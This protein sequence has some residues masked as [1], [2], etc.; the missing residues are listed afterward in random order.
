M[1]RPVPALSADLY[2]LTMAAAYWMNGIHA[3]ASFELFVR[4]IGENRN[5]LIAAGIERALRY[6]EEF[7]FEP[8]EIEFLRQHPA[9]RQVD[10]GF[11]DYLAALRFTG[12]VRAM[13]EGTPFF[14]DEPILRVTAPVIQAQLFETALLSMVGF[15]TAVASK[16]ARVVEA[17]QGHPVSE[18]G[19]RHA[20]GTEAA[21]YAARAA[22][23]AGC[24]GT[25]NS[26][27]GLAFGIPVTGT[28]AHSYIMTY[29][30]ELESFIDFSRVIGERTTLLLDTYDT[31]RALESI[32]VAGLH[33]SAVRLDSGDRLTL[34][35]QVR[36]R[37]DQAGLHDVK[38]VVT[39]ELNEWRVD[40]LL[41]AGAP[42]D[43]F[44]VGTEIA[45]AKDD[46]AL[47]CVY[48]LVH[49]DLGA[50]PRFR[51]KLSAEKHT[52]PSC[53]Q[54]YRFRDAQGRLDHDV[55]ASVSEEIP[56]GEPLLRHVVSGGHL[57]EPPPAL[58]DLR[59]RCSAMRAELPDHLLRLE[60]DHSYRVEVTGK[61]KAMLD[62][63]RE[64]QGVARVAST[65]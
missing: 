12:D 39:G 30:D 21:L 34:S 18:F 25:S 54:V 47:S 10:S 9:F 52:W 40:E 35:K 53:K 28:M 41:R 8:E 64:A 55:L 43:S 14:A 60:P 29:S 5:Y 16:A 62:H 7:H 26:E 44:G 63:L 36:A 59:A 51:A 22:Y 6:L 32:L 19:S 42:I 31:M 61:L 27:A 3:G 38:I 56:G 58:E 11:F 65:G 37:L 17:A 24:N 46:P 2:E 20:H 4:N 13:A 33:P 50:G 45:T 48:K 1:W 57:I 23:L 15:E 49:I